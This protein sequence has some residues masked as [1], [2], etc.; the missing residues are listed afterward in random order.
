MFFFSTGLFHFNMCSFF[1]AQQRSGVEANKS[2]ANFD[3]FLLPSL[4]T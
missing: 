3:A 4:P 1:F 2:E